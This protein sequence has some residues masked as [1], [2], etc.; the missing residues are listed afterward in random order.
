VE[1]CELDSSGSG[2]RPLAGNCEHSDEPL[3]SIKDKEFFDLLSNYN[4][5][6]A[7]STP[8]SQ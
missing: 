7:D 5:F 4:L 1:G 2:Q 6:T 3:G 8:W